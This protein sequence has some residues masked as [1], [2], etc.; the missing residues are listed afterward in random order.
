M[1]LACCCFSMAQDKIKL[2]AS[3]LITE[4]QA[5]PA[6]ALEYP[7]GYSIDADARIFSRSGWRLGGVF[8]FQKT[9]NQTV[10]DDYPIELPASTS[11]SGMSADIQRNV[12]TYSLGFQ[13]SKKA[14]PVEPFGA[15]LLGFRRLH[16]DL[17]N[18]IVR[19]YRLG[20]DVIFHEKSNFFLRPLFVEFEPRSGRKF[21][22]GAGFRF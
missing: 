20:V 13:L 18:E 8:N 11:S 3:V 22:A 10:F 16:E 1:L 21:G 2:S 5:N 9:Y 12:S 14:G 17:N 19:K 7:K 6:E 15:F 4:L